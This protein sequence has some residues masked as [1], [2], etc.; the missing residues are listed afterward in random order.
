MNTIPG[1][2]LFIRLALHNL[3]EVNTTLFKGKTHI[4]SVSI[5]PGLDPFKWLSQSAQT[6]AGSIHLIH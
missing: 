1:F 3:K 4:H 5:W 2:F 6:A